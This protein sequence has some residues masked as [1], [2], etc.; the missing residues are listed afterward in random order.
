[1]DR[2]ML[3]IVSGIVALLMGIV[4]A[5]TAYLLPHIPLVWQV[6]LGISA[7]ALIAYITLDRTA[8]FG[9]LARK[10]TRYGLNSVVMVFIG[11]GIAVMVN[12]IASKYDVKKDITKNK[13]H[14]LSDQTVKVLNGLTQDVNLKLFINP[15]QQL[16]FDRV[17]DKYMSQSKKLH[18]EIVDTDKDPMLVSKYAVKQLGTIIVESQSRTARVEMPNP[19]DAKVEEKLTNAI[20]QVAKGEKKKIYFTTGHGERLVSDAG[21]EG[22]SQ[23]K[24]T[25]EAGRYNV[26]ELLLMEKDKIPTDA[27]IVVIAGAKS[28]FLDHEL[29][30]LESYVKGGGKLLAMVEPLGTPTLKPF[31]EGL[32]ADWNP[33]KV[34]VETNPLQQ[35]AGGNPL[36]PVV[37]SYDPSHE[38]TREARQPT[39]FP[40]AA[41]I[42][43][44]KFVPAGANITTLFSTSNKSF[45]SVLANNQV[46]VDQKGDRKGPLSLALAITGK[47]FDKK[48]T[49]PAKTPDAKPED[50]AKQAEYRV[51]VVGDS[52]FA[53]NQARNYSMNSDMFQ[54]MLSWLSHEEDLIAIR[55]KATDSS[56]FDIT[57]ERM[58]II[59]LASIGIAPLLFFASA[60]AM[61]LSRRRR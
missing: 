54:N 21:R 52:D 15:Q 36:T 8:I 1:M 28:N 44:A 38:I 46:K 23:V 4:G 57:A 53:S 60:F 27:E 49:E 45:E 35:L 17:L 48:E 40:I 33:K 18:K 3:I 5:V 24:E 56:Q 11:L 41:P 42:E 37:V 34:I 50:A 19:D 13:L 59:Y 7:V 61:W 20:I 26:Q 9:T 12:L 14:T 6:S 25:L 32:G 47:V 16:E 2:N 30:M 58:R 29:K 39:I 10:N 55:P 31:L 51:I 43:K 22:F